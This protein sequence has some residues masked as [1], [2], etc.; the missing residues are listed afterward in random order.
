MVEDAAR[1]SKHVGSC[2]AAHQPRSTHRIELIAI[3][4]YRRHD[5]VHHGCASKHALTQEEHG[6]DHRGNRC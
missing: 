4:E 1:T 5:Q 2:A 6:L 3:A